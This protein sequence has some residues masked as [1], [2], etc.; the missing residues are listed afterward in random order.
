MKYKKYIIIAT[1]I[2]VIVHIV[3]ARESLSLVVSTRIICEV[4]TFSLLENNKIKMVE[5]P[6]NIDKKNQ[7]IGLRFLRSA[8]SAQAIENPIAIGIKIRIKKR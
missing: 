8:N 7:L 2:N 5:N 3:V 6:Q 4:V 1:G